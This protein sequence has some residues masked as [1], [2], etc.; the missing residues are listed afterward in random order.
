MVDSKIDDVQQ[1]AQ[2]E[3]IV[4][5][6]TKMLNGREPDNALLDNIAK[7]GSNSYYY[8]HAPKDFSLEGAQHF[9]GDGKI[10]GGDPVL[11]KTRTAAEAQEEKERQE[12][13]KEK[14]KLKKI[15]KF[16]WADENAK[17]KIY[18]DFE[19]FGGEIPDAAVSVKFDEYLCEVAISDSTGTIN[20]LQF[21]K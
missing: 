18:I 8:A 16:S 20:Q 10:Y 13:R 4:D 17:V 7:K 19:Q 1:V 21:Y 5:Q 14:A 12:A 2:P 15:Q 3:K 11:I 9:K 6:G